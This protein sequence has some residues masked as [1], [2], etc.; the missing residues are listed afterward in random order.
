VQLD[1]I[2][3]VHARFRQC[4]HGLGQ[5]SVTPIYINVC[6]KFG[7]TSAAAAENENLFYKP[8]V[9]LLNIK[10]RPDIISLTFINLGHT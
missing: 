10:V 9:G 1:L 3:A 4:K 5:Q 7:H 8:K 6:Y 2:L